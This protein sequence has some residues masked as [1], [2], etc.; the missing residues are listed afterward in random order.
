MTDSAPAYQIVT[1]ERSSADYLCM[2]YSSVSW[3]DS[4]LHQICGVPSLRPSY[5]RS[6]SLF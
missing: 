2:Y 4:E 1:L 6:A 3:L 5:R